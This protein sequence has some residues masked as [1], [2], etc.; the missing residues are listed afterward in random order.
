[1]KTS[2]GRLFEIRLV[3]ETFN[4]LLPSGYI[5]GEP[6]KI[7]F[8]RTDMSFHEASSGVLVAKVA[9]SLSLVAYLIAGLTLTRI[10]GRSLL[11][12][13]GVLISVSLLAL[14]IMIFA[15]LVARGS[16]SQASGLMHRWTRFAWFKRQEPRFLALDQSLR[17]FFQ[18]ERKQFVKSL[19]WH[20]GGWFVSAME[21][22]LI[23]Y[24]LDHP[25]SIREGLFMAAMAQLGSSV[26][27][28]IPEGVGFYEGGHY[29]AAA[30]LGL[31]PFLGLSVGLIRRVRELSWHAVG[32]GM[33]WHLSREL[34]KVQTLTEPTI[35]P[36]VVSTHG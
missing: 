12:N 22:P 26:A 33:F 20:G 27:V 9:Q 34:A 31:P 15:Y 21:V 36:A 19:L 1:L 29:L 8:L 25:F 5:G 13:R 16:F 32:L 6:L 10:A 30:L 3:G 11:F 4:A 24:L 14:G 7:K 28:A 17:D 2:F 18:H 35:R 23:L